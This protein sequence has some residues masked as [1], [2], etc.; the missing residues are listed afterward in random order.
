MS[1]TPSQIAANQ[2]NAQNPPAPP[3]PKENSALP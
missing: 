3:P 1:A 2:A